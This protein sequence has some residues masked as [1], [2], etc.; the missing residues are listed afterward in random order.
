MGSGRVSRGLLGLT[1]LALAACSAGDVAGNL[2]G[3][4]VGGRWGEAARAA[5]GGSLDSWQQQNTKFSPEQ[6][7]YL[8]RAVAAEAV[9]KYGLD[10]HEPHQQ[11]VREIGAAIV[12]LS[13]RLRD[14]YGGYHFAVLDT[15]EQNGLSGP[16]G[17]VFITRGALMRC[18]N[19]DEVA[20]IL[21]H[22]LAHVS[23]LHGERVI[24]TG[25]AWQAGAQVVGRIVGAAAD[26]DGG[27]LSGNISRMLGDVSGE[28][29]RT[30]SET[31]YGRE[32][33]FEADREGTFLLYDVGYDAASISDYLKAAP[34]RQ[35][36]TWSTHPPAAQRI[37][38]LADVVQEYGGAFDG[39]AGKAART[40][41]YQRTL[42][43]AGS[44]DVMPSVPMSLP[45]SAMPATD[46]VLGE[47]VETRVIEAPR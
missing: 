34:G 18:Q 13:S 44:E 23:L 14:T 9:A 24:R 20:A 6:E 39:G 28:L 25:R 3:G 1:C 32:F 5:V 12:R 46:P 33:E 2:V 45:G 10:P 22:E 37:S 7:Y 35:Q 30:L 42:G 38:A 21:C 29:V 41:R 27:A 40:A 8:G 36:G 17:Y 15:D 26:A 11:Y 47:V 4:S 16:G 19:E 31:G 43:L